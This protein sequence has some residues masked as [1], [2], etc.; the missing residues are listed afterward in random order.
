MTDAV[1]PQQLA[2]V[3]GASSGI[4]AATATELARRGLH[5][6]AG[7]RREADADQIRAA[8]VEPVILDITDPD[9]VQRLA[10]RVRSDPQRR[11]LR[12][13]V[14]N[15][16][17]GANAPVEVFP[18]EAWRKLFEVNLFGQVAVTQALLPVLIRDKGRV[19]NISSVGGKVAMATYGPYAGTKFALEAVSDALRREVSGLGVY[20]VVVEPSA[21]RTKMGD[22][23]TATAREVASTMTPE[24]EG[25]YGG[26][27]R[28][29]T[30]QADSFMKAG[31]PAEA[32]AKVIADVVFARKP[33]TRYAVGREAVVMTRMVRALSDRALDRVLAMALKPNFSAVSES[34][35][36]P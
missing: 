34:G 16:G 15:A 7:V 10:E 19:I 25:R 24:Q 1:R 9:H 2:V 17:V 33:R 28:A 11:P 4:G 8:G 29:I 20:V 6:L 12:V 23:A 36:R 31:L 27:V 5:V 32:A 21:V 30:A 35:G 13:L 22:R 3:T 18:L 14:N 26:L